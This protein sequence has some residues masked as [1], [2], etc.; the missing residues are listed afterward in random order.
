[1][2]RSVLGVWFAVACPVESFPS[3]SAAMTHRVSSPLGYGP[4]VNELNLLLL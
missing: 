2:D 1:M 3:S 4:L